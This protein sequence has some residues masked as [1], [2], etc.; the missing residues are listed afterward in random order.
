A[1]D[2]LRPHLPRS[3]APERTSASARRSPTRR[4]RGRA[5]VRRGARGLAVGGRGGG[6]PL[7][8]HARSSP[9]LCPRRTRSALRPARERGGRRRVRLLDPLPAAAPAPYAATGPRREV[10]L[11]PPRRVHGVDDRPR[12]RAGPDRDLLLLRPH[13]G[14]L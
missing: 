11:R 4:G 9:C 10:V 13:G 7:G 1:L 5:Y 3:G 2:D 8:A 14:L 6:R 12:H